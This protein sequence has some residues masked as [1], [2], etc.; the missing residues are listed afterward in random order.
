MNLFFTVTAISLRAQTEKLITGTVVL[1]D[2]NRLT[3][4][5]VSEVRIQNLTRHHSTNPDHLG[6]FKINAKIGDSLDVYRKGLPR[7][8]IVVT[9]YEHVTIYLDST[10]LLEE[11]NVNAHIDRKINLKETAKEYSRQNSIYFGGKPP[12]ALLSPFGG[13]P[14]TFFRELLGKDGKRVRK[15]NNYVTQQLE[16][17]ELDARFNTQTI[18]QVIP[19]HDDEIE[20]FKTAYKPTIE[21]LRKWSVYELYDYIKQS[22]RDFKTVK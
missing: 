10:I 11:V 1:N 8:Q 17:D 2:V 21:T 7:K 6:N 13:S 19:I 16:Q 9:T 14:I 18:K 22:Y 15:F 3:N 12:I 20:A 5:D 4:A